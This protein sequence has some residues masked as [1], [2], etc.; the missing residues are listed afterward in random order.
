MVV[1]MTTNMLDMASSAQF[2]NLFSELAEG[3]AKNQ[4]KPKTYEFVNILLSKVNN[5]ESTTKA[6]R[7]WIQTVYG[8]RVLPVEIP[9][10]TVA[11]SQVNQFATAFDITKY[12]GDARTYKRAREAYE[13]MALAVEESI[14][15]AWERQLKGSILL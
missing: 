9:M 4:A 7:E 13:N 10:T 3:I 12:E 8:G 6:V 11:S 14:G 5:N 1:P 2:W 15:L